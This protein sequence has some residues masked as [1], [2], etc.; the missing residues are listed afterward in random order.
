MMFLILIPFVNFAYLLHLKFNNFLIN[1]FQ[2]I[3]ICIQTFLMLRQIMGIS[4]KWGCTVIPETKTSEEY[5]THKKIG[6]H[7]A[8]LKKERS[9]I[10]N[11]A[12]HVFKAAETAALG[13]S[14]VGYP[15]LK[16]IR[17]ASHLLT[18][19]KKFDNLEKPI[20]PP[21]I[22]VAVKTP[23]QTFNHHHEYILYGENNGNEEER[24][25]LYFRKK[26]SQDDW[27]PIYF[28]QNV[29]P[30]GIYADGANLIV[31]TKKNLNDKEMVI[32]YRKIIEEELLTF[33]IMA[34]KIRPPAANAQTITEHEICDFTI[35]DDMIWMRWKNGEKKWLPYHANYWPNEKPLNLSI[36]NDV[37]T[38]FTQEN[39]YNEI[40]T[41]EN[42]EE[43]LADQNFPRSYFYHAIEKLINLN[44]NWALS[45]FPFSN[46][47]LHVDERVVDILI[48]GRGAYAAFMTDA[49][50]AEHPNQI[51][52]TTIYILTEDG[53]ILYA[54]PWLPFGFSPKSYPFIAD[55]KIDLPINFKPLK[56]CG[57]ASVIGVY[58]ID[59]ETGEEKIIYDFEDFD[60]WRNPTFNYLKLSEIENIEDKNS[61]SPA[62]R[63]LKENN[64]PD[65]K[66]IS[67]V[68][69]P[70][71]GL[72]YRT[73]TMFQSG[74]G[75]MAKTLRVEL[76]DKTGYYEKSLMD[77]EPWQ[78]FATL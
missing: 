63:I 4:T 24:R 48:T 1:L 42:L 10:A 23:E 20:P 47:K 65:W 50:G 25:F 73:L 14:I 51:N 12:V 21:Q 34:K 60:E 37:L 71:Y 36:E 8:W 55:K 72:N 76:T 3:I 75:T 69:L 78:F 26:D 43:K 70:E 57:S 18:E 33:E 45:W 11:A 62:T 22:T 32:E 31:T 61:I 39:E 44:P 77:Q 17:R 54:D 41:L 29:Y 27:Q 38:I 15:T 56:L 16:K 49:A 40:L 7:A 35:K 19:I 64:D 68:G 28:P 13:L 30:I 67:L 6:Q 58:G 74:Q 59:L 53:V 5:L 2:K 66:S 46:R 9:G 52:L